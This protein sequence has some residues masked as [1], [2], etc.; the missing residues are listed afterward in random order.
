MNENLQHDQQGAEFRADP[1]GGLLGTAET[2]PIAPVMPER[3]SI[4]DPR[5]ILETPAGQS[6]ETPATNAPTPETS[7]DVVA[8][9]DQAEAFTNDPANATEAAPAAPGT[10]EAA[11]QAANQRRFR[12]TRRALRVAGTL[13]LIDVATAII[14]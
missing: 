5:L 2:P 8:G 14:L 1:T 9:L 7:P 12:R 3:S 11:E 6:A 13:A 10:P 4:P